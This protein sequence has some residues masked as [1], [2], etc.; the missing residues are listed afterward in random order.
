MATDADGFPAQEAARGLST[1]R[2]REL[3]TGSKIV[4]VATGLVFL[5]L[6][7]IWQNLEI[8]Y[9]PAGTGTLLLD[10]WDAL[11]LVIGL[12]ALGLVALVVVVR[13]SEIDISPDIDWE[14]VVLGLASALL[15]LVL[16]K[17]L[18]DRNSA[19]AS[20]LAVVLAAGGVVGAVLDRSETHVDRT[21]LRR[22]RRRFTPPAA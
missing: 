6:F 19:W 18:T 15:L 16:A 7:L 2:I 14:F 5:S 1:A 3:S 11:G 4:L 12:L 9:G 22:R 10:G 17:N 8:D 21:R 20:Y 13:V